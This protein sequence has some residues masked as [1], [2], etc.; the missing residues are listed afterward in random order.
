MKCKVA[1]VNEALMALKRWGSIPIASFMKM[2][3][4]FERGAIK[5]KL[6]Y[7]LA[8]NSVGFTLSREIKILL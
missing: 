8:D 2:L 3:I 4:E 6:Y 1:G 7:S 5:A